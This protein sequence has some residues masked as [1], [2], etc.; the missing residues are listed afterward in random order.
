M[1]N[2]CKDG[3]YW[4]E[5]S[6]RCKES[7]TLKREGVY[8]SE[9]LSEPQGEQYKKIEEVEK[10]EPPAEVHEQLAAINSFQ[11]HTRYHRAAERD[12]KFSEELD[13]KGKMVPHREGSLVPNKNGS[14]IISR[15]GS[16]DGHV[17]KEHGEIY[18]DIFDSKVKNPDQAWIAS[19]AFPNTP[20]GIKEANEFLESEGYG[21]RLEGKK[22]EGATAEKHHGDK[23][24][25][26]E[27]Y[28]EGY[29]K[30][31]GTHVEGYCRKKDPHRRSGS[32]KNRQ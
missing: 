11:S 23:C 19:E 27:E 25:S 17:R 26:D 29:T 1:A 3:E 28:V 24:L 18:I 5:K 30:D 16:T 7:I 12:L 15:D 14:N 20:R 22:Q 9:F 2:K 10:K 21:V 31:D 32:W 8:G 4:D 6:G 13:A